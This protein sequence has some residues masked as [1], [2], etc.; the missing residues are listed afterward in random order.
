MK[1]AF[2]FLAILAIAC[3]GA[4]T[5]QAHMLWLNASDYSPQSGETVFVE[6]GWGHQFPHEQIISDDRLAQVYA[7]DTKGERTELEKIFPSFYRFTPKVKGAYRIVAVL[8]SG[9]LSITTDGHQRGNRKAFSNVVSCFRY[10]MDAEAWI[11]VGDGDGA[12][13]AD[14]LEPL[15][16]VA[17]KDPRT[18]KA[19]ETLP[20]K[21]M[22]QGRPLAGAKVTGTWAGRNWSKENPWA[23][24]QKTDPDGTVRIRLE[25]PGQWFFRV[26]HKTPYPDKSVADDHFYRSSLTF[27]AL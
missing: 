16:I 6:I 2:I 4:A 12:F 23:A 5:A 18:V 26:A 25:A 24:E 20:M 22:F 14:D 21:V 13:S 10:L 1:N 27:E 11:R 17:M 19:G 7:L 9:F 8:E 3:S 15:K